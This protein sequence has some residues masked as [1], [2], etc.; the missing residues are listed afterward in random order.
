MGRWE[1]DAQ[2]RLQQAALALY[3]ERGFDQTTVA[4][5]A[6][7]A[8]LTERT[9]FRY[10]ADKR[11]VLFGGQ[12]PLLDQLTKSVAEAPDSA[13]PLDAVSAALQQAAAVFEGR[14]DGSR[15]RQQVID[16]NPALQERER[17][18]R[19]ALSAAM[20]EGL[21]R[22]G[23]GETTARLTGEAGA[24]VFQLAFE[25]WLAADEHELAHFVRTAV[26]DLKT[27]V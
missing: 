20:A 10:F 6:E 1:P 13:S 25:Q 12:S 26:A 11:E 17:T 16:A 19:S 8:G 2:G 18:K 21:R 5:I 7:R 9:F 23:V 22:R 4:E 14:R 27:G 15:L 3:T 24:A